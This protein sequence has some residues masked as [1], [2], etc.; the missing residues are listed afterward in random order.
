MY[1]FDLIILIG[2]W[3]A[4]D[5]LSHCYSYLILSVLYL[6]HIAITVCVILCYYA[7]AIVVDAWR[8]YGIK[9]KDK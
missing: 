7:T 3:L 4:L 9:F 5:V 6:D 1:G 8:R 2:F